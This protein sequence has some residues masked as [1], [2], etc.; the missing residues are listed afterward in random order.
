MNNRSAPI[1]FNCTFVNN[2]SVR[3]G[4]AIA[5][6]SYD[7]DPP[8]SLEVSNS[9]LWDGGDEI[10]DTGGGTWQ[11][12]TITVT[13]C[14]VQAGWP[15]VGN[16]DT[17]PM[18]VDVAADDY[19]LLPASPCIDAGD[20]AYVAL[21]SETDLDGNP[22]VANGRIDMGA[23]ERSSTSISVEVGISPDTINLKSQGKYITVI[24][25]FSEGAN[26]A[27]VDVG[28][29]LLEDLVQPLEWVWFDEAENMLMVRFNRGDVQAVLSVGNN[30]DVK[31]TGSFN[32]GTPFEGTGVVT[33]IN[34]GGGKKPK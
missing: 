24:L 7:G 5:F 21:P 22:R 3:G 29:I 13:Y 6:Y 30:V 2:T 32:D 33:V 10:Y 14:D 11:P 16:I 20:P 27:D 12:S 34:K 1:L 25:T 19:R 15:G 17:D 18:F 28:S 4:N 9:I 23:Y 8:S 26:V 31:I